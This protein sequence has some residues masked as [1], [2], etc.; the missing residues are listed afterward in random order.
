[1]IASKLYCP[2]GKFLLHV[3]LQVAD[4]LFIVYGFGWHIGGFLS[5]GD[6]SETLECSTRLTVPLFIAPR[7][8]EASDSDTCTV[9]DA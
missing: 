5:Q 6:Y 1:M 7:M 4:Y 8:D 2:A 3:F 9:T